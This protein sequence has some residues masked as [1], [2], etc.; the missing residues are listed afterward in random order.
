MLKTGIAMNEAISALQESSVDRVLAKA[1]SGIEDDLANGF[2]LAKAFEKTKVFPWLV[3]NTLKVGEKSGSLEQVF[4]DLAKY[5]SR[6]AEFLSSL[7]SAVIYPAVVFCMLIGIMFYV[8]FKVI[9]HLEALLPISGNSL[10]FNQAAF[11][12]KP[13][14]ERLLVCVFVVSDCRYFYLFKV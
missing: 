1:L 2:S 4:V 8:S 11:I 13:F 12:F 14:P 7:K 6:E 3:L 9:P 10:F 5:Y